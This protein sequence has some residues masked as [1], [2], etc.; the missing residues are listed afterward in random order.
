MKNIFLAV[1]VVLLFTA[2]EEVIDIDLN[3][4]EPVISAEGLIEKDS[5]AWL[6]LSYSS[7]YF[8]AEESE[9]IENAIVTISD[10]EGNTES[11]EHYGNGFYTGN[12]VLGQADTKYTLDFSFDDQFKSA[13]SALNNPMEIYAVEFDENENPRP[14][15]ED[16][17]EVTLKLS[18]NQDINEFSLAKFWV[19]NIEN[20]DNYYLINDEYFAKG[21]TI[22]YNP[23]LLT[24]DKGDNVKIIVYSID[25]DTY[26]YYNQLNDLLG[27]K[28]GASSTPYNPQSNFGDEVMGYFAAW[29]VTKHFAK[30]E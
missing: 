22:E 19:N 1:A 13:S 17:Y 3:S 21:D 15:E 28:M 26:K 7:D 25:E 24:F 16:S 29:S 27:G 5:V 6:K 4:S 10:S 9:K 11:L 20:K 30:V 2:C 8:D 18:N 12:N 23:F 14:G